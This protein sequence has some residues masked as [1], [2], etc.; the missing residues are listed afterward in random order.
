MATNSDEIITKG[1]AEDPARVKEALADLTTKL[2]QTADAVKSHHETL[3][4][5]ADL[6]AQVKSIHDTVDGLPGNWE[7]RLKAIDDRIDEIQTGA[8][9][10]GKGKPDMPDGIKAITRTIE[11]S[12]DY[13]SMIASKGRI[14]TPESG[15]Q[16]S[17]SEGTDIK[18]YTEAMH[19][20]AASPIVI[21]D[22]AGGNQTAYRPGTYSERRWEMDL[23]SRIPSLTVSGVTKYAIPKET[24]PSLY[25]AVKTVLNGAING[26]PTPT[27]TAT[28]TDVDG[29]IPGGVVR[30]Y[31]NTTNALIGSAQIVSINTT[32]KVVTFVTN[33]LDFDAPDGSKCVSENYGVS[34]EKALKPSGFYG[35]ENVE[36]DLKML[37]TI[38]P[39]TVNALKT[40][41]GLQST[42]EQKLPMRHRRNLS[43]HLLYGDDGTQK[44]QG[45]RT[46][47]GAQTYNWSDGV[48][49]DNQ[50]DAVMRAANLIP[51]TSGI[52]VIMSQQ[53]LPDLYL[54][55]GSDGHYLQTGSFGMVP[56]GMVGQS[57]YLGPYEMVFDYAVTSSHFTVINWSDASEFVE[58][59]SASLAWG[60]IDDDFVK[61]IIRARYEAMCGHAI[62]ATA[63]YI[64]G[65]WDA[66]P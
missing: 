17:W 27:S 56:F 38:L 31:N 41:S 28:F 2:D 66:A 13:K 34:A 57:W 4:E 63:D 14:S 7:P 24:Q 33:S 52:G 37:A 21:S 53:D 42:L 65:Q 20:K 47:T 19:A 49:G 12:G 26:D 48:T 16:G 59:D 36:F 50:A 6:K 43:Y 25:G 61:N 23:V 3:K 1:G 55:K 18:S 64:V 29:F 54:L 46:Y 8:A 39:T 9:L 44:L 60:Y 45:L 5:V 30:F 62:K 22:I 15:P 58:L 40:F 10:I 32:T 35:T 11:D 51:W